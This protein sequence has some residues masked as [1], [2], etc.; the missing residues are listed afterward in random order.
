MTAPARRRLLAVLAGG[1]LGAGWAPLQAAPAAPGEAVAWPRVKLLDG[2]DWGPAQTQ[3]K[4][5]VAVFWSITCPF[6]MRHNAHLEALRQASAGRPLVLIGSVHE[7]DP[8][9]V[10][11]L[12]A[13]RGWRFDVTTDHA[14]MAAALS[15]R[16]LTPLTISVDREGRLKQVIPG[17]MS[18]DDM[19]GLLALAG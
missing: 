16:R 10:R 18:A 19:R 1:A 12:M 15:L 6:C 14:P 8:P 2:S 4:A 7:N 5:V 13:R 11:A 9:A 3:G 17:E